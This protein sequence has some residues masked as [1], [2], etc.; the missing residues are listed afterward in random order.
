MTGDL[1]TVRQHGAPIEVAGDIAR[2]MPCAPPGHRLL[3]AD[4]TGI[5]SV[6]TAWNAGQQDKLQQWAKFFHTREPHDDPYVVI[7][8][9]LGHPEATARAKGKIADLAFGYQGGA[10]AYKNFAPEEDTASDADIE[11]YKQTWRDRQHKS[12]NLGTAPT[13]PRLLR[14]PGQATAFAM[15]GC[16]FSANRSAK[17][18]FYSSRCRAVAGCLIR[19]AN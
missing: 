8:R 17:L 2:A 10:G 4:F 6:L 9:A 19:I 3:V 16:C 15:A 5:E 12:C 11:R 13:A 18:D 7:G 14:L 1:E